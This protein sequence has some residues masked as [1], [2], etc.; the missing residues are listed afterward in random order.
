MD[1]RVRIITY[2]KMSQMYLEELASWNLNI[3]SSFIIWLILHFFKL[4]II[5]YLYFSTRTR[6]ELHVLDMNCMVWRSIPQGPS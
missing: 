2:W 3:A 6:Y 1:L 4:Q 5:H